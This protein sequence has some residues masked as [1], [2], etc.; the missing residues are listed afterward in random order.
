MALLSA[1]PAR[2]APILITLATTS[3]LQAPHKTQRGKLVRIAA[4]NPRPLTM[5]S[6]AD[7]VCAAI[8][9]GMENSADHSG[10]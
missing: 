9:S 7:I 2:S 1:M 8:I 3:R 6:L 4:A 10:R 5:P